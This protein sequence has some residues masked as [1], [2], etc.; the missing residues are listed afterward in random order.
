[1][2]GNPVEGPY[3]ALRDRVAL[4]RS[5]VSTARLSRSELGRS[6]GRR[7]LLAILQ[8]TTQKDVARLLG[9][10]PMTVS[11]WASG[12]STPQSYSLRLALWRRLTIPPPDW[13]RK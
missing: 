5:L 6:V 1:M 8:T 10:A 12:Q 3:R 7:A 11:R 9:V 2:E 4:D 13:D